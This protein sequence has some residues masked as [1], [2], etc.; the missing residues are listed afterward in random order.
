MGHREGPQESRQEDPERPG[1]QEVKEEQRE[2]VEEL[3]EPTSAPE[4][5]H[6][7][8]EELHEELQWEELREEQRSCRRCSHHSIAGSVPMNVRKNAWGCA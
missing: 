3:Q 6:S 4:E 5:L 7:G 2:E 1:R 8:P